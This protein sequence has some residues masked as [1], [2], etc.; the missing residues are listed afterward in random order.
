MSS[1]WGRIEETGTVY[2][3][4][5]DGEREIGSWQ[6]G[7]AEAGLA[8]FQRRFADTCAEVEL[9]R[10]RLTSGVAEAR[11]TKSQAMTLH[12]S[13]PTLAAIG[14]FAT[15][16][17][18][19]V[20]LIAAADLKIG[21]QIEARNALRAESIA[22][23]E[24]LIAE[25]EQLAESSTQW[26]IAGDRLREIVE[27]W[28]LIQ[29]IDRKNDDALWK[30]Y[31]AARDAFGKR[32]GTHFATLDSERESAKSTKEDLVRRAEELSKSD[33]W[34]DAAAALKGLMEQWKTA[35]RASRAVEDALWKQF[36]SAQDAFFERRSG[37]F[38]ER[39]AEQMLN[40]K[41]KE[42]LV[43]EAEAIDLTNPRRA[44]AA[45]R[46]L[47]HKLDGVGHVPREAIRR[48]DERLAAAD[49]RVRSAVDAEFSKAAAESNPFLDLLKLRLSE[50]EQK[51]ARAVAS[52]DS[53][54]ID[55]AQADVAQR[56]A[57]LP[58]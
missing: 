18:A 19:L 54:R 8:F 14:D 53:A 25:A 10:V 46:E 24:R 56:R 36:R 57:L 49:Q 50:A 13:L 17:A 44:Q 34:R 5:V 51:L 23:K 52:G 29:G 45:L 37:V 21:E 47:Q 26:K 48:I 3:C 27:E 22:K 15:L 12:A 32:R 38:A 43:N 35:P 30:R 42:A 40:L 31:A 58:R 2:V 20:S 7:D 9:M 39:D 4:T 11:T 28:K 41:Q 33:Q 1:E 6:A 55:R 16:D